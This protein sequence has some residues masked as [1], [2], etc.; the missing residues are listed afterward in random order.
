MAQTHDLKL[1]KILGL[2]E[3]LVAIQLYIGGT[4]QSDIAKN[5]GISIGKV[6]KLVSGMK[7]LR[8]INLN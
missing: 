5:L 4:T 6:N 8:R 2:L 1:D 3:Q 7:S